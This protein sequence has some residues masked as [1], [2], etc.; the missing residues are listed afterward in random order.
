[1]QEVSIIPVIYLAIRVLI[2]ATDQAIVSKGREWKPIAA[3]VIGLV[4]AFA[5]PVDVMALLVPDFP[6]AAWVGRGVTG[7]ALAGGASFISDVVKR[8]GLRA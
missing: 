6:V 4:I 7:I 3:L 2:D 5:G 8:L 1:M